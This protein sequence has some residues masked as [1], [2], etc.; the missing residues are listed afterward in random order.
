MLS[1]WAPKRDAKR[2]QAAEFITTENLGNYMKTN[3][4]WASELGIRAWYIRLQA[5][6]YSLIGL[7]VVGSTQE[8]LGSL[9]KALFNYLA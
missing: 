6:P 5:I 4:S 3:Q 2:S 8:H 7:T 9:P 1:L